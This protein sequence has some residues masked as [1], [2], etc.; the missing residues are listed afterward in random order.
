MKLDRRSFLKTVAGV[1]PI[2]ALA[3][4]N[5]SKPAD[6]AAGWDCL[7]ETPLTF[8]I[9]GPDE[10]A[11]EGYGNGS[12]LSCGELYYFDSDIRSIGALQS[13]LDE[14]QMLA[15]QRSLLGFS[16]LRGGVR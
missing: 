3:E 13:L 12:V 7:R 8:L 11:L 1:V 6:V 14:C 9:D 4:L 10:L 5:F 16:G 15:L 2:A